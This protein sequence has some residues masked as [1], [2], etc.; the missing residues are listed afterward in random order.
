MTAFVT[1]AIYLT[2]GT[3]ISV[4]LFGDQTKKYIPRFAGIL[5]GLLGVA[6]HGY[7]LYQ[8]ILAE[9][10]INVSFFGAS[11]LIA[12]TILVLLMLSSLSKPVENL[13]ISLMPLAALAI[14]LEVHF[15]TSTLLSATANWSLKIHV[16]ISL[17]AYSLLTMAS[18]QA[19]LLAIQD[20]YLRHR[21]PGGIIRSFPPP[22]NH[23][24]TAL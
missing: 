12:W 18:V 8:G 24:S 4:R 20:H 21:H 19:V 7:H 13:A 10:G 15:P 9:G 23:G 22:S 11:S 5:I 2:S 6:M 1:I 3:L 17:L 14:I 16:L